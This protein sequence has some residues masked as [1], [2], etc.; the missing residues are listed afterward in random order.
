MRLT[1]ITVTDR[2][3]KLLGHALAEESAKVRAA[4]ERLPLTTQDPETDRYR[5][6]ERATNLQVRADSFLRLGYRS[7]RVLEMRSEEERPGLC[8]QADLRLEVEDGAT[9]AD[10]V[11]PPDLSRPDHDTRWKEGRG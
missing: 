9:G 3:L 5:V 2:E 1:N 6:L 8:R 10:H 11:D 7:E 4:G